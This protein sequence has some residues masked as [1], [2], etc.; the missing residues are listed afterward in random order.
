MTSSVL[1]IVLLACLASLVTCSSSQTLDFVSPLDN[2]LESTQLRTASHY[3]VPYRPKYNLK[4]KVT[5]AFEQAIGSGKYNLTFKAKLKPQKLTLKFKQNVCGS[6]RGMG[7][8]SKYKIDISGKLKKKG[9]KLSVKLKYATTKLYGT[10]H[11][12]SYSGKLSG[13]VRIQFS[14]GVLSV[15]KKGKLRATVAGKYLNAT[16]RTSLTRGTVAFKIH[17]KYDGKPFHFKYSASLSLVRMGMQVNPAALTRNNGTVSGSFNGTPF[18]H[19]YDLK[20]G[21]MQ[22]FGL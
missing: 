13:K 3:A 18:S 4:G 15:K 6:V 21:L 10:M 20:G 5:G 7:A 14:N 9:K 19:K 11:G 1:S 2:L 22:S 16:L 8:D 12:K 17:G